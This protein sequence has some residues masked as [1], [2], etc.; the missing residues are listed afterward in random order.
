MVSEQRKT[1]ERLA[2]IQ[3]HRG[4][5]TQAQEQRG[6]GFSV[7]HFARSLI[8]VPCSLLRNRTESSAC[9]AGYG[10]KRRV[11][12]IKSSVPL[13]CRSIYDFRLIAIP[14]ISLFFWSKGVFWPPILVNLPSDRKVVY[15]DVL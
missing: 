7:P 4:G 13:L 3:P 1:E 14:N 6:T 10:G 12:L 2:C 5:C 11:S 8:L 15:A 9:Y